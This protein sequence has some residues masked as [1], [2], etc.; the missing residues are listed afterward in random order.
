MNS[1]HKFGQ[2]ICGADIAIVGNPNTGK[3]CL[4]NYLT[5][6]GAVVSN[7][8]GTTVDIFEGKTKLGKTSTSVV[9]LPGIYSLGSSS[10]DERVTKDYLIEKKPKVIINIIDATLLERNLY[11]T[12]QLLTLKAPTIIALNFY[13]ELNDKGITI[14][15]KELEKLLGIPV[16]P[17]DALRGAG[18]KELTDK[19]RNIINKKIKSKPYNIEYDDHIESA[20][21]QIEKVVKRTDIPKRYHAIS[22]IEGEK[23]RNNELNK[24]DSKKI[25]IIINK[26]SK[27]H[28]LETQI[29]RERHGQAALTTKKVITRKKARKRFRDRLDRFTTEPLTGT[30]SLIAVLAIIFSSLFYLGGYLAELFGSLFQTFILTPLTP[31]ISNIPSTLIQTIIIWTLDGINAGLQIML[32]YIAIFYILLAFLE[33]SG[34][35][36]RMAYL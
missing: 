21:K 10:E 1:C 2:K 30:L 20:I 12:L 19:A 29:S 11:L 7:Y 31:F 3:S 14:K 28:K 25:R 36:P 15:H 13:E 18:I 27:K 33:D 26:L 9:D 8:P 4:F 23:E 32:P 16:M 35:L 22:L 6:M 24:K 34:Y 5:G 17:I